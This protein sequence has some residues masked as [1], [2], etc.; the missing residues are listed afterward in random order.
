MIDNNTLNIVS[1]ATGSSPLKYE[2]TFTAGR[3]SVKM[4]FDDFNN[5]YFYKVK[6]KFSPVLNRVISNLIKNRDYL[7]LQL[8]FEFGNITNEQFEESEMDFLSENES[9]NPSLLKED[10][11]MLIKLSN[12][13]YNAEEISTM[14]NCSFEIAEKTIDLILIDK[15]E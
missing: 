15:A 9:L 6:E 13:V 4:L 5:E 1:T 14:F 7:G 3:Q 8:N 10:V 12:R 2:V 11:D